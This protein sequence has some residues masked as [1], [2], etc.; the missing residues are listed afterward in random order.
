MQ[1]IKELLNL[2]KAKDA[3]V[4]EAKANKEPVQKMFKME[5]GKGE[6]D[7]VQFSMRS[8]DASAETKKLLKALNVEVWNEDGQTFVNGAK[9]DVAKI[10]KILKGAGFIATK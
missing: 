4:T 7:N 2:D 9:G 6:D 3:Q 10:K 8:R 5:N 1:L